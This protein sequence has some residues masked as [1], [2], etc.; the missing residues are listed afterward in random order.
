[1]GIDPGGLIMLLNNV[2]QDIGM[3]KEKLKEIF[4]DCGANR[5]IVIIK[6]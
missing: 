3:G 4:I 2:Q 6:H 5:S 1:M